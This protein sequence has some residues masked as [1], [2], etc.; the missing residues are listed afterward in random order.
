MHPAAAICIQGF[1]FALKVNTAYLAPAYLTLSNYS[2]WAAI[3]VVFS[4]V[5]TGIYDLQT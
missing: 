4:T 2:V 1:F 5:F 3:C